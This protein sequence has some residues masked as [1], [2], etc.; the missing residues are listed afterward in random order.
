[1]A[2]FLELPGLEA[3]IAAADARP[4]SLDLLRECVEAI[5]TATGRAVK[6][7]DWENAFGSGLSISN[8]Q[9]AT[10]SVSL[11]NGEYHVGYQWQ[12]E[13]SESISTGTEKLAWTICGFMFT[14]AET[15]KATELARADRVTGTI[16]INYFATAMK[17]QRAP[18]KKAQK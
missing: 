10:Y 5:A 11:R 3:Q 6:F 1:M 14:P 15:R 17:S 12:A 2:N 16:P 9:R 13:Q 8:D 7:R 4:L 18:D